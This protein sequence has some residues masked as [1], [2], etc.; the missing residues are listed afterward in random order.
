MSSPKD[1]I[2][3]IDKPEQ[4][5]FVKF[6]RSLDPPDEGTIRLFERDANQKRYYT[7]H[8][9]NAMYIARN[10]YKTLSVVKYWGGDSVKGLATTSLSASATEAFLR[11]ALLQQQFRVEIWTQKKNS[12]QWELTHKA[13]PGNLQDVEDFLFLNSSMTASPVVMSV[14]LGKTGEHTMVGVSFADA[15]IKEIGVAEFIDNELFSN[16]ESLVI[17]LGVKECLLVA[18]ETKKDYEATKLRDVLERCG[19]VATE[20]KKADFNHKNIEQDLNRLLEGEISDPAEFEMKNAMAASACLI[21]YLSLLNDETTFGRFQLIHHDLSQY[22]RLDA[23]ALRA[24]N[25]MPGPQDGSNRTMSLYG[26]L[27]RCK[28][29]QGSRLLA[30]WL[31][32]PLLNL[33]EIRR[34]QDIL[35]VF[36]QD[37]ELYQ[38]LQE[39]HL[40]SVPDLH[41]LAKRFQRGMASLQD[42][43]RIYQVVLRLPTLLMCLT[44]H[45]PEEQSKAELMRQTYLN[46]LNDYTS[47]LMKLQE[48]VEST[49]DLEAVEQHEFIIK[50]DFDEGLQE[51]R[52]KINST[53]SLMDKEHN[54]AG[55]KL[56]LDTEKK[57]KLEKHSNFGYCFRVGRAD[58]SVIRN[59]PE[60]IEYSTQ[61]VGTYFSTSKLRDLSG[62]WSELCTAYEKRQADLVKEVIGIVATYC[63]VLEL[64]GGVLAHMDVLVSFAHVS[65][66]APTPY[67]R[68]TIYPC[69]EGDV[70][71]KEARHPCMEVQDDITFIPNDVEMIRTKSEFQIITGPNMGGKSTYIRQIGVIA[72]MAQVGCFVPCSSASICL[73]DSILARV[74]AGDSQLKGISTFMA[75]MLDTATILKS[76]TKNSL[77]MIDE[78]GRGTST[79]DG[80]GLAWAISEHIATQIRAFCLFATHFHEL[81]ALSASAPHVKN[82]NVAVY[83]GEGQGQDR[84]ITF[85]HKVNEGVCDQSF[86]IHVA[87]LA[88]FPSTVVKLAKRKAAELEDTEGPAEQVSNKHARQDIE[89]IG[90]TA[91]V[92]NMGHDTLLDRVRLIKDEFNDAMQQNPYLRDLVNGL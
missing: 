79:Y 41:R 58:A 8:D 32:Q 56:G 51:L 90:K 37:T 48:L 85:L 80:F 34:R 9:E 30:Q 87:E 25:L 39:D 64:L 92:D 71:L 31:K 74:G 18:D 7:F 89:S 36:Y 65:I 5:S 12:T 76:A 46:K 61:K 82:L 11:N 73:F 55:E 35:E 22:M 70:I 45:E 15:T 3:D 59:K 49:I 78:L 66:T 72:L 43:V 19:I 60:Y 27:N 13:S 26:L 1:S 33:E 62:T 68:P 67:I 63:P 77:I 28:T 86:G 10:V 38:S 14:K 52:D 69:G 24:L 84:D 23:S 75:E 4:Q 44:A 50:P 2:P 21:K 47:K 88:N 6:F 20:R 91:D 29:A 40:K 53:R 57:L 81:T 17:Q 54:K 16:L 83:V 42:V